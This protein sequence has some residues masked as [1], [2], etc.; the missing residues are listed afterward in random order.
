[1]MQNMDK[2]LLRDGEKFIGEAFHHP[3]VILPHLVVASLILIIDFF[4]MYYLFLQGWWGVFLFSA[5]IVI[6]IY[7][8]V[9]LFFLYKNNK[10]VITDSRII[11][12]EQAGFFEKFINEFPLNRING[13]RA[14]IKGMWPTVFHYGTLR[15]SIA[16]QIAPFELYKISNPAELQDKINNLISTRAVAAAG[17]S[18]EDA[19][20]QIMA[21]IRQLAPAEKAEFKKQMEN[22]FRES[23][24]D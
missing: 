22:L 18:A 8:V 3:I 12:L 15:L 11:D 10:L 17:L 6:V 14:M 20:A 21:Q 7:Y 24:K 4:L 13:A 1:M 2:K 16:G 5:V 9:R 23:G 19:V